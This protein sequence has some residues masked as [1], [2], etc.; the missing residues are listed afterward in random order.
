MLDRM[1]SQKWME[2]QDTHLW[3]NRLWTSR[4]TGTQWSVQIIKFLWGKFFELWNQRNVKVHSNNES[5]CTQLK[6]A[7]FKSTIKAM[8]QFKD[9][10][11][12]SDQQYMF[13]SLQELEEFS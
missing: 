11:T 7:W 9:C 4:S 2:E 10:L 5:E 1:F 3:E 6:M 8:F 13:Q 12:A